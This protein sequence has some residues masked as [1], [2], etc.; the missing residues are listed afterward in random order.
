LAY[1]RVHV[2]V[3][4]GDARHVE[5]R[6]DR[7]E[8]TNA[9]V[10]VAAPMQ[11]YA[12]PCVALEGVREPLRF[13]FHDAMAGKP[14]R[15]QALGC[16]GQIVARQAIF[17]LWRCAS[18]HRDELAERFVTADCRGEEHELDPVGEREFRSD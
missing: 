12:D 3:A 6:S 8:L 1:P 9:R 17:A 11:L 16:F 10:V 14:D 4:R 5:S 7:L 18:S 15:L 2:H 13:F